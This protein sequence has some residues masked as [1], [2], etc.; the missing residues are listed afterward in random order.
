MRLATMALRSWVFDLQKERMDV[1][2]L[3][4]NFG[5]IASGFVSAV[6]LPSGMIVTAC[7][8]VAALVIS[9][10]EWK[11]R[12][13]LLPGFKSLPVPAHARHRYRSLPSKFN[14][15][16]PLRWAV[17]VRKTPATALDAKPLVLRYLRCAIWFW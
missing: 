4:S 16:W 2:M 1:G 8:A 14:N 7:L 13:G 9:I 10:G 12:L 17:V 3:F 15:N 6:V 11:I 5:L